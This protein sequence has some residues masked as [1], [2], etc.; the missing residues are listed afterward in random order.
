MIGKED[1]F[2]GVVT[3]I[4]ISLAIGAVVSWALKPAFGSVIFIL[5]LAL[6]PGFFIMTLLYVY[7]LGKEKV[8][9]TLDS[10]RF[11]WG[12]EVNLRRLQIMHNKYSSMMSFAGIFAVGSFFSMVYLAR[13]FPNW[14]T[15][16]MIF[17]P[18]AMLIFIFSLHF[19]FRWWFVMREDQ[20][21]LKL[22]MKK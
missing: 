22:R 1:L 19:A 13:D 20:K 21:Y 9:K 5:S 14:M 7:K 6:M 2:S 10:E 15:G 16:H 17:F 3:G 18:L 8:V 4:L 11:D 12:V